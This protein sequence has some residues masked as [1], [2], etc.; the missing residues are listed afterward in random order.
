MDFLMSAP[1]PIRAIFVSKLIQAVLPNFAIMCV[2]SLPILFGLGIT[3]GYSFLYYPMVV[4]VL[5]VL[6]LAAAALASLLVMLAARSSHRAWPKCW[7]LSAER[8]FSLPRS[9]RAS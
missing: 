3:S 8:S 5:A 2:F 4:I 1:I 6:S 7:V 9:R